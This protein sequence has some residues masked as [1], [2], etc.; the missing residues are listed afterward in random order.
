MKAVVEQMKKLLAESD[1]AAVEYL[2]SDG[3]VLRG[4]FDPEAYVR[5]EQSITSYAFDDAL[6]G[7]SRVWK[8]RGV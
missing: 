2:E 1:A 3:A 8:G 7:L 4:L 6:D 5:F